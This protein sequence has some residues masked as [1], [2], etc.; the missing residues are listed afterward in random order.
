VVTLWRINYW[1]KSVHQT[2]SCWV[3]KIRTTTKK[4]FKRGFSLF[5]M[6]IAWKQSPLKKKSLNKG[7]LLSSY[8]IGCKSLLKCQG[9]RNWWLSSVLSYLAS[10]KFLLNNIF[11]LSG[12]KYLP[13]NDQKWHFITAYLSNTNHNYYKALKSINFTYVKAARIIRIPIL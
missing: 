9:I 13:G 5:S 12:Q 1:R 6:T 2:R 10:L 3:L 7:G 11:I 8:T 4:L